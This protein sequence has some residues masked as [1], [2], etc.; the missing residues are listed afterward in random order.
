MFSEDS[1]RGKRMKRT[2]L[3]L[4]ILTSLT[5]A[6]DVYDDDEL[7]SCSRD[8]N[9]YGGQFCSNLGKC[10]NCYD[11]K[12]Y[13]RQSL[14]DLPRLCSKSPKD[15]GGCLPGYVL[16]RC[17]NNM[18]CDKCV[19]S[20]RKLDMAVVTTPPPNTHT[21]PQLW[22]TAVV[23]LLIVCIFV[24][25]L[26]YCACC[27]YQKRKK[28]VQDVPSVSSLP[29]SRKDT[30]VP[31]INNGYERVQHPP[32]YVNNKPYNPLFSQEVTQR[33][34]LWNLPSG[35]TL[36]NCQN[37]G[38][39]SAPPHSTTGNSSH[40]SNASTAPSH[41]APSIHPVADIC[42]LST[43]V[44]DNASIISQETPYADIN[45]QEW[46]NRINNWNA[47]S[48]SDVNNL[49]GS[50][51]RASANDSGM[52]LDSLQDI[53]IVPPERFQSDGDTTE[54]GA[55]PNSSRRRTLS[56]TMNELETFPSFTHWSTNDVSFS[57]LRPGTSTTMFNVWH[58]SQTQDSGT[59]PSIRGRSP[60]YSNAES[61]Y[62][63]FDLGVTIR[64]PVVQRDSQ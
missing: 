52:A 9:C 33:A 53:I 64:C 15:C 63:E 27:F 31:L 26:V 12:Y 57:T 32:P 25:S 11:C 49:N 1:M 58:S 3:L 14:R 47:R 36:Q 21:E 38:I 51:D 39:P 41:W 7:K 18:Y 30:E 62:L 35:G 4:A 19:R 29:D 55:F 40:S 13:K 60:A 54:I 56:L 24:G 44:D 42:R 6:D 43:L 45:S 37:E 28:N 10:V 20:E 48:E 59:G 8:D 2:L 50:N 46:R 61:E 5:M 34:D 23:G 16:E 17:G 22:I